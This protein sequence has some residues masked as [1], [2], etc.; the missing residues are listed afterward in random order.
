[1]TLTYSTDLFEPATVERMIGQLG[2]LLDGAAATP[3]LALADLPLLSA[4]ERHQLLAEWNQPLVDHAGG[5]F[6][7]RL[8][9]RQARRARA[10]RATRGAFA[11]V[12]YGELARRAG[13]LARRLRRAGARPERLVGVCARPSVELV[14]GLLA[15]LKAGAAFVPLDPEQPAE[16]LALL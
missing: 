3:E 8:F 9:E 13:R 11:P 14:A 16:R 12:S 5:G 1:G 2:N 10:R 4:A 15:V 6:V 7:H